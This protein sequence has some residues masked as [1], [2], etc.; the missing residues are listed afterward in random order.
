MLLIPLVTVTVRE[1]RGL[2]IKQKWIRMILSGEKP[3]EVRSIRYDLLGQRIA[4]GNSD[5]GFVEGYATVKDVITFPYSEI[6]KYED[7]HRATEWLRKHYRGRNI[8]YG[9]IL[10]EIERE[11]NPFTYTKSNSICFRL[12]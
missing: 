4:L 2:K 5:N 7:K 1:V 8:L 12:K 3:M 11:K 6:Q 9:F 10:T